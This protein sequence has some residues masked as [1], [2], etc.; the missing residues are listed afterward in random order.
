MSCLN[1]RHRSWGLVVSRGVLSRLKLFISSW[2]WMPRETTLD[3][4]LSFWRDGIDQV[5]RPGPMRGASFGEY[6]TVMIQWSV[7]VGVGP[8]CQPYVCCEV[9]LAMYI[10]SRRD[11]ICWPFALLRY[12]KHLSVGWEWRHAS[13]S[14]QLWQISRRV[15]MVLRSSGWAGALSMFSSVT[16]KSLSMKSGWRSRYKRRFVSMFSQ[17]CLCSDLLFGAYILRR[18][19]ST[20]Q[21][22]FHFTLRASAR[23]S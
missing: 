12:V 1:A 23:P 22:S 19:V 20:S 15:D 17:N 7:G 18:A 14:S 6:L 5:H 16:L 11:W 4:S 10:R 2:S 13:W 21:V 9:P 3:I 8:M